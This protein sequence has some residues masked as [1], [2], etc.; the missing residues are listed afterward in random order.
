MFE[1]QSSTYLKPKPFNWQIEG[2]RYATLAKK[3]GR[4][5]IL[6]VGR[7]NAGKTTILKKICNTTNDPDI[8]DIAGKKIDPSNIE[9]TTGRGAHNIA[10]EMIFQSNPGF[11]FH[12][13][14][15]FEAGGVD[16]LEKVKHFIL[17]RSQEKELRNRVHVIW[18]CIPMNDSRPITNAEIQFFSKIRT[19]KV[20]VIAVF[21]KCEGLELQAI[22]EL[23]NSQQLSYLDALH[24]APEYA[25]KY[26]QNTHQVLKQYKYAPQGHV[27]LQEMEKLI[28][29]CQELVKCTS[30]VLDTNALQALFI[31]TQQVSLEISLKYATKKILDLKIKKPNDRI[32]SVSYIFKSIMD[33]F[34]YWLVCLLVNSAFTQVLL[35]C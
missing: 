7:A 6:V 4:F 12:D 29:D 23:Q 1:I 18:Y 10:N 35:Y 24:G 28:T 3:A 9:P 21:T 30:S 17:E 8:Y 33:Y 31:S 34:P 5:R 32:L 22:E 2:Q 11:I 25:K 16:E 27:Y 15:G 26:L 19:G 13:S 14:C 20:P